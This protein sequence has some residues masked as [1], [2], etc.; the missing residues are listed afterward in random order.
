MADIAWESTTSV[1]EQYV[2]DERYQKF[3]DAVKRWY[4]PYRC[5]HCDGLKEGWRP[6]ET[7]PDHAD[8]LAY[9]SYLYPGDKSET[10]YI[11]IAEKTGLR[12]W[13]YE[14]DEGQHPANFF[15]HWMPLPPAP[16]ANGGEH[17]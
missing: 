17:G 8:F 16:V 12:D 7:A 1:Y 10:T 14:T 13:P 15:S 4:K 5:S 6:I 3:S 2:T 9:G 11:M